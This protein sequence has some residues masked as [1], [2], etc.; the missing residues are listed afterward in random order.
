MEG[1]FWH[2]TIHVLQPGLTKMD[3]LIGINEA[4]EICSS[5]SDIVYGAVSQTVPK[6]LYANSKKVKY[7][8]VL[9]GK[10][11]EMLLKMQPFLGYNAFSSFI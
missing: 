8:F 1:N 11:L 3:H 9:Y 6:A 5:Y 4:S 2:L 7:K 10:P